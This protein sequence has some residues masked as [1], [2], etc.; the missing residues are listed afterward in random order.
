M[1]DDSPSKPRKILLGKKVIRHFA[2]RTGIQ[3]GAKNSL[4]D[5]N[6]SDTNQVDP[7][8]NTGDACSNSGNTTTGANC[9]SA[10]TSV[11]GGA[12][13]SSLGGVVMTRT[14]IRC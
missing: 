10:N 4:S 11:A 13:N 12:N 1:N 5:V 8:G 14:S 2:V 6:E 9:G 7:S 3:T